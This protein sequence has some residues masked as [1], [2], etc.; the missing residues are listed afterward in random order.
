MISVIKANRKRGM[1]EA[2]MASHTI[3][4]KPVNR[5]GSKEF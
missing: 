4:V 1:A 2:R 5:A 3:S